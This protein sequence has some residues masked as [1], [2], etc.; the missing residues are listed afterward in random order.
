[1]TFQLNQRV[2]AGHYG[3]GTIVGFECFGSDGKSLE[4]ALESAPGSNSRVIVQLDNPEAWPCRTLA[5]PHPYMYRHKLMPEP[6]LP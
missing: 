1:M 2:L 4:P 5:G 6:V 3:P